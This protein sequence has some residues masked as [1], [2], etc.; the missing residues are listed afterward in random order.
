MNQPNKSTNNKEDLDKM[1]TVVSYV[2]IMKRYY[3]IA[4]NGIKEQ[5]DTFDCFVEDYYSY[6]KPPSIYEYVLDYS[7]KSEL[8][9][10]LI[11]FC[12]FQKMILLRF[13]WLV[14]AEEERLEK[15]KT[16]F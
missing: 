2:G 6:S 14:V 15:V 12:I 7:K 3:D 16:T 9:S 5:N 13:L 10:M 4:T 11:L 8:M 1:S